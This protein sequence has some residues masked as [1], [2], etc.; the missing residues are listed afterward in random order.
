MRYRNRPDNYRGCSEKLRVRQ[1]SLV[2]ITL[3]ARRAPLREGDGQSFFFLPLVLEI[4]LFVRF[5]MLF[6]N[7]L[8]IIS[9][10]NYAVESLL[11]SIE[12]GDRFTATLKGRNRNGAMIHQNP[13]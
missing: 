1:F 8:I 4:Y 2:K 3:A 13:D 11:V 10:E 7:Y 6:F 5:D 9:A 12:L